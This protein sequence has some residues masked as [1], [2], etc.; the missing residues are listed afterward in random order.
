MMACQLTRLTSSLSYGSR[1][2]ITF[3][4]FNKRGCATAEM[5]PRSGKVLLVDC[6]NWECRATL[7]DEGKSLSTANSDSGDLDKA[8]AVFTSLF[9]RS[10]RADAFIIMVE[11]S[12]SRKLF[13]D[14]VGLLKC[15]ESDF[16]VPLAALK[17]AVKR[18]VSAKK[19]KII[20]ILPTSAIVA[21]P[22]TA[23]QCCA[24]W[25]L[26]RVCQSLRE[27]VRSL[28]IDVH[29]LFTPHQASNGAVPLQGDTSE[30]KMLSATLTRLLKGGKSASSYVHL[31]DR[32]LHP[33]ERL[34]PSNS[35][36]GME[37]GETWR[38][39]R[40]FR[41]TR[42]L[43]AVITGASS[44][45]GKDLARLYAP[46]THRMCLV[47]RDLA[48]LEELRGDIMRT[49]GCV[50]S[51]AKVDLSDSESVINFAATVNDVDL[52]INCAGF[53]VV[54]EIKDI[55][56]DLF[57]NNMAVNFFTPVF[58]TTEFLSKSTK[59]RTVVNILS[60]TAVAGRRKQ[61]CY[62]ATK[63]AL[64][65]FTRILRR[66]VPPGL[67]VVEVLPATFASRFAENSIRVNS[68]NSGQP[69]GNR[70]SQAGSQNS[71]GLTSE[72]VAL[73][74]QRA[75]KEGREYVFVLFEARLFLTL[76]AVAPRL[77]R[78][79]FK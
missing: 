40:T 48:A 34:F 27:E 63:A 49:S 13:D 55:P 45:L 24:H 43:N 64:W 17:A 75:V 58:L 37:A 47:G 2:N 14:P 42:V 7:L 50:A 67:Q 77:F 11:V 36:L 38:E 62:S 9:E 53:S 56:L 31:R 12:G 57:R 66:T 10:P 76:E 60:T 6:R 72:V 51:V 30:L 33:K 28:N 20:V 15:F 32:L 79:L 23:A 5:L 26:R 52:L 71:H 8:E 74:I 59:P 1:M 65:A 39:H 68:A 69:W 61:G 35:H 3:L 73:K 54:G 22:G 18:M 19:G 46:T 16:F 78:R 25:A 21:D 4:A 44:G 29:L 41:E 70:A